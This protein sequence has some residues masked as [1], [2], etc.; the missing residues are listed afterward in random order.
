[1]ITGADS[2]VSQAAGQDLI[3]ISSTLGSGTIADKFT[4]TAVPVL[5]WEASLAD[6]FGYNANNVNGTTFGGTQ[7]NIVNPSHPLAAGLGA[8]IKTVVTTAST[9]S[10]PDNPLV[11]GAVVVATE[12]GGTRPVIV[13]IEKG[14]P[15]NPVRIAAAPARR[16]VFYFQDDTARFS[17]DDGWTLFDSAVNWAAG[18]TNAVV[19]IAQN[20][21][22]LTA[23]E[24][25]SASFAVIVKGAPPWTF[26]WQ[27][28]AAGGSFTNVPGATSR[29]LTISSVKLSDSGASF[30][31]LATNAFGNATSS[32]AT[33]TVTADTT[34]PTIANALTGG[35][36][37]GV[38]VVFSEAVSISTGTNK[39]NFTINNGVVVNSATVLADG[40]TVL[41][42]TT[43]IAPGSVY[44]VTVSG[45]QDTAATPNTILPNSTFSFLQVGGVIERRAFYVAG[46]TLPSITNSAKFMNNQPDEVT[47]PTLF[48][49]PVN[50]LDNYGTQF[51]G[52]VIPPTNGDYVF[53]ICSD[54]NSV[55]FLSTDENPANKHLIA[56]ETVWSNTRQWNTSGGASD[57]TAKRS[58]QY[59]LSTWPTG[60]QITLMGGKRY[61]IEAIHAE[62][63][64]GD[65][66]AVT[67]RTPLDAADPNDGDSPIT[68]KY[69]SPFAVAAGPVAITNQPT[70]QTVTEPG[71]V[72]FT[73]GV[74]G[75]PAFT[76][77]WLRNGTPVAG[78]TGQSYTIPFPSV[79]A[80]D[81]GARFTVQVANAF[82]S[83]TSSE[84]TLTVIPDT[85]GPRPF[86]VTSVDA[87]FKVIALSF[88]ELV[89]QA[90]AQTAANYVFS[91]GNIVATNV[92]LDATA[93][94]V[95][96]TTGGP[97]TVGVTNT[98]TLTGV[99][100]LAGNTTVSG[101]TIQF[102]F[103]RVTYAANILFDAPLGYYRFEEPAGA[104]VATNSGTTG[105]NGAYSVG[106]ESAPGAGGSPGAATADPGPRPPT[107]AGFDT[108]NHAMTF[109]GSGGGQE[110]VDTKNQFLQSLGAF[111]LEYWVKPANRVADPGSFGTRIG[112][113]GQNDAIEYGFID[114]NTIQIWTPNGGSLN[115]TYTFPDNEW[116][117]VATIAD[118]TNLR[119]YYD[120]ALAGTG[121]SATANYGTTI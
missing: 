16:A 45:V 25:L 95:T 87:T 20:P 86:Q 77:Q 111:S 80:A 120:G 24:N 113:V 110:W 96:I 17:T 54:D 46:G 52:Y 6:E 69:L 121:G 48:E 117:H 31:V 100:D 36:P 119:T 59:G 33:L 67:W 85:T 58:D 57:L 2:D 103:N 84:A 8:G 118:G 63:G 61:Y 66:I 5:L 82:S 39:S 37:N 3:V 101:T 102:V 29:A 93:T 42:A 28:S 44:I 90:S 71:T 79:R 26:Q 11:A 56:A 50:Y 14:T 7:I 1:M 116:H 38:V 88:N 21:T 109:T 105:G 99:K 53:F 92:T 4:A 106:D 74:S 35:N 49:G 112:L 81:N 55:L 73:V 65:N 107:F 114:A 89:D 22:N 78:A 104:T 72:T 83:A 62:G 15:L 68:G 98:L 60:N 30:R 115:T 75:S 41:L 19:A 43:P 23:I 76:Y 27:R 40:R 94:N 9:F 34:K 108:N 32:A 47:Y 64:G 51:R 70:S 18:P 13:A 10:T 97:L 91:P 12:V